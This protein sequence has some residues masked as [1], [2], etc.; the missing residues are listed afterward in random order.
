MLAEG[1]AYD[2]QMSVGVSVNPDHGDSMDSLL[3][4]ADTTMYEA[5]RARGEFRLHYQ[6]RV[7]LTSG[8]M[9]VV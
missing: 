9:R 3:A 1:R 8:D 6:P 4:H 5:K 7:D 2:I